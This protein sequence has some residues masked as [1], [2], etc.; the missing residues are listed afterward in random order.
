MYIREQR[1]IMALWD[2]FGRPI[3]GQR[4]EGSGL[5]DMGLVMKGLNLVPEN[6]VSLKLVR[7]MVL[8]NALLP[9]ALL[10]V[11]NLDIQVTLWPV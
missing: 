1:Q 3:V 11:N 4:S 9:F 10:I 5:G 6:L 7:W 8:V 2:S